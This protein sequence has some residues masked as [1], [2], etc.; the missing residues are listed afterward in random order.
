MAS[1]KYSCSKAL[2][3]LFAYVQTYVKLTFCL[4]SCG[5][6]D[7]RPGQPY[8]ESYVNLTFLL[9]SRSGVLK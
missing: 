8:V 1:S 6:D 9:R 4:R 5:G 7:L 2:K 3:K